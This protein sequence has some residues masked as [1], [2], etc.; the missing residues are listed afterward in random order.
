MRRH[1]AIESRS[2][3]TSEDPCLY[4]EDDVPPTDY[5]YEVVHH[6]PKCLEQTTGWKS[7]RIPA[8]GHTKPLLCFRVDSWNN[9]CEMPINSLPVSIYKSGCDPP[10]S[11]SSSCSMF[12]DG[13]HF[14]Q[15]MI[16]L[17]GSTGSHRR[18]RRLV[19]S[20]LLTSSS[21]QKN[22][23]NCNPEP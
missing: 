2:Q 6:G 20:S 19:L 7:V 5:A 21:W 8:L 3:H 14:C 18:L 9:I 17:K 11:S 4:G 1:S 12:S 23:H 10:G 15:D 13:S 16:L 22:S